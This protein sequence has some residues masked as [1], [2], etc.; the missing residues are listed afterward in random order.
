[1]FS[2]HRSI[3]RRRPAPRRL[4]APGRGFALAFTTLGLVTAGCATPTSEPGNEEKQS[5][6]ELGVPESGFPGV[7]YVANSS[8]NTACTG[9]MI[10]ESWVLT[11]THC[12][13][14]PPAMT[15]MTDD[16]VVHAVDRYVIRADDLAL[17]HLSL[18]VAGAEIIPVND[19]PPP[20][21]ND[22]C[23]AVGYGK[24]V[25]PDG[26]VTT[27]MKRSGT[28]RVTAVKNGTIEVTLDTN[29][30][31]GLN[32][33]GDSGGPLICNGAIAAV[34]W[35]WPDG[36]PP[37]W[38]GT[39]WEHGLRNGVY[40]QVDSPWISSI[41]APIY[42]DLT[43]F[44]GWTNLGFRNA[45]AALVSGLVQLKGM[46]NSAT[47]NTTAFQLPPGLRPANPV[48]I[49]LTFGTGVGQL[50]ITTTGFATVKTDGTTS[51]P[52]SLEGVTFPP[53]S[54][55]NYVSGVSLQSGWIAPLPSV[56]G[57][58]KAA[59]VDGIVHLS[60]AV[61][62][63]NN[64]GQNMTALILPSVARPARDAF[65]PVVMAN[66]TRGHLLIH[67]DG[68]VFLEVAVG[69][70]ITNA[71]TFT[72]FEGVSYAAAPTAFTAV[73][74]GNGWVN[75]PGATGTPGF[76]KMN[77]IVHLK[78]AII[79][80]TGSPFVL[81]IGFRPSSTALLAA[82]FCGARKGHVIVGRDGTVGIDNGGGGAQCTASLE[83]VS[84]STTEYTDLPYMAGW[85]TFSAQ[86]AHAAAALVDGVVHL[87]G[88]MKTTGGDPTA[89]RLPAGMRPSADVY[90]TVDLSSGA[91]GQL[92]IEPTGKVSV[93]S[94]FA[95]AST[96]TSL[97][98]VSLSTPAGPRR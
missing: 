75:N 28:E 89:F 38:F 22:I 6:I 54:F 1:M 65:L 3:R 96:Y 29:G 23:L 11:A 48:N 72:S 58:P 71:L 25:N 12:L 9:T 42:R 67:N 36:T 21:V 52:V 85:Q 88:V 50:T 20:A 69:S 34:S 91:Q 74:L 80:G 41:V 24:H 66:G 97:N 16:G 60:G 40:T 53:N 33:H 43:L 4:A 26:S 82:D 27:G 32:D 76:A 30:G 62:A 73:T 55:T 45:G 37:A 10:S 14:P 95:A 2:S 44:S 86:T 57:Q 61:V 81:P 70:S 56:A 39:E 46:I 51:A 98:G 78:G 19:G 90:V 93:A 13:S 87:K 59:V 49:P 94:N 7:G 64:Q 31:G 5:G 84:F 35:K 63:Q 17:M 79:G 18:P 8:M 68:R 77:G 15:F 83:G 92:L 47:P